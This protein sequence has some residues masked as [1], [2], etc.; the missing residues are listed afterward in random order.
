[1]KELS[2]HLRDICAFWSY[3][4]TGLIQQESFDVSFCISV[5]EYGGGDICLKEQLTSA[6]RDHTFE[7]LDGFQGLDCACVSVQ[8]DLSDH[9]K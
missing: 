3:G 9:P 8:T 5:G 6:Q 2:I 4:V 1:M 7:H